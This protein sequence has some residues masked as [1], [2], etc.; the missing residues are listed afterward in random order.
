MSVLKRSV[1]KLSAWLA[2]AA[3]FLMTSVFPVYAD[4][5]NFIADNSA[6][7]KLDDGNGVSF[8]LLSMDFSPTR[9]TE[10]SRI[11]AKYGLKAFPDAPLAIGTDGV[12]VSAPVELALQGTDH[13]VTLE[14]TKFNDKQAVFSYADIVSAWGN[15]D[16]SGIVSMSICGTGLCTVK[17]TALAVTDAA[18]AGAET[19]PSPA[20]HDLDIAPEQPSAEFIIGSNRFSAADLTPLSCIEAYYTGAADAESCPVEMMIELN[21]TGH[22]VKAAEYDGTKA[23]FGYRNIAVAA[24]RCDMSGITAFRLTADGA[25]ISSVKITEVPEIAPAAQ[26]AP[27]PEEISAEEPPAAE[28][29]P[30]VTEVAVEAFIPVSDTG[31]A[32]ETAPRET[33]VNTHVYEMGDIPRSNNAPP[34]FYTQFTDKNI[35]GR[36]ITMFLAFATCFVIFT[37]V[38]IIIIKKLSDIRKAHST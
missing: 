12:P 31:I 14:P 9:M 18:P 4:G 13:E 24:G 21:G 33:Q 6:A 16:L 11:I 22:P 1:L 17:C 25:Q 30:T 37:S 35:I 27:A 28:Q 10:E 38:I 26:D 2:A 20:G 29:P 19:L 5:E 3:I 32:A 23:V 34:I 8:M 7:V 36:Y 15:T